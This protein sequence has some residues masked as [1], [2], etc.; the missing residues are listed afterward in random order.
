MPAIPTP[1]SAR[2]LAIVLACLALPAAVAAAAGPSG[3]ATASAPERPRA[4]AALQSRPAAPARPGWGAVYAGGS[5]YGLA[6]N[7]ADR[8]EAL[9]SA[10]ALCGR[11]GAAAGG[12]CR[13]VSEFAGRCGAVAQAV[14]RDVLVALRP[15]GP[16]SVRTTAGGAGETQEQAQAAAH[17]A[18]RRQGLG[19]CIVVA[20]AC[21]AH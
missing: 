8:E 9:R 1:R 16:L 13:L 21:N 7:R 17:E 11:Q 14:D 18:C 3:Q 20:A 19:I 6:V 4:F 10:E 5:S 2:R 12:G 15:L